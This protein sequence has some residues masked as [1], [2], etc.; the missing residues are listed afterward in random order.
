MWHQQLLRLS[1]SVCLSVRRPLCLSSF[2]FLCGAL[3]LHRIFR[4]PD[5]SRASIYVERSTSRALEPLPHGE[6]SRW[7]LYAVARRI[8]FKNF[9]S[10]HELWADDMRLESFH[11]QLLLLLL[12][13]CLFVFHISSRSVPP[14][15]L[16][17]SDVEL[18][19]SSHF[20][21]A[22]AGVRGGKDV[23]FCLW[24][25]TSR[26]HRRWWWWRWRWWW[27]KCHFQ[28]M[29]CYITTHQERAANSKG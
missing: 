13:C 16:I 25:S 2:R 11:C 1:L 14:P 20:S 12:L 10:C 4:S 24:T 7:C 21:D 29:K 17:W 28:I 27:K 18:H 3:L 26:C 5:I 8:N 15:S 19:A 22:G 9:N 6:L 23:L